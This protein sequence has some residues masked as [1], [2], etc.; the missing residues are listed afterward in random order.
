VTAALNLDTA[1]VCVRPVLLH[2]SR[3]RGCDERPFLYG[4]LFFMANGA[5]LLL[6]GSNLANL[7]VLAHERSLGVHFAS[8]MVV[9]WLAVVSLTIA[10]VA[11]TFPRS[12]SSLPTLSEER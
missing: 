4:A 5:S 8:Q 6:P 2:A 3:R 10:F 9:P 1:A 12:G 11:V 7:I